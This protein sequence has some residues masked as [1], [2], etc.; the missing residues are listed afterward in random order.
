[1]WAGFPP[2]QLRQER[3]PPGRASLTETHAERR[4]E[5]EVP[6]RLCAPREETSAMGRE[7]LGGSFPPKRRFGSPAQQ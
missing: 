6:S 4:I 5:R 3:K 7:L 2:I 1:M